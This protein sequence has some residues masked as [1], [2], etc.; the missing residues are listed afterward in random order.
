E[1]GQAVDIQLGFALL[2]FVLGQL[3]LGL[4]QGSLK[5]AAIDFKEQVSCFYLAAFDIILREKI[6]GYLSPDLGIHETLDGANPFFVDR[7]IARRNSH[8]LDLRG[9]RRR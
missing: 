1:R 6:T 8:N 9:R 3:R 5:R 4:V 7:D 2:S